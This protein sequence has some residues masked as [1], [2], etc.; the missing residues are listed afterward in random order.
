MKTIAFAALIALAALPA[1][2]HA[3]LTGSSPAD[4]ASVKSPALIKLTFSE[5]L[6]PLFSGAELA[7]AKGEISVSRS[8]GGA[9]I[10][11]LPPKLRPGT[12]TV[13]WHSVGRDTHR[14]SGKFRF[15]VIP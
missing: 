5:T 3:R 7:D 1:Q 13:T 12:Y 10:T 2:A 9:V 6:E 15:T 14:L 4:K 11:L 8:V